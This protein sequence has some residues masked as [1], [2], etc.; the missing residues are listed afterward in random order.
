MTVMLD[1]GQN[2]QSINNSP[3]QTNAV[4]KQVK[5]WSA[6][7]CRAFKKL[8]ISDFHFLTGLHLY[9]WTVVKRGVNVSLQLCGAIHS[10]QST[11]WKAR[12]Y[13]T[14]S[15]VSS[16]KAVITDA[17]LWA[18]SLSLMCAH[19]HTHT[20]RYIMMFATTCSCCKMTELST[21]ACYILKMH[22]NVITSTL[23]SSK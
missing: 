5:K 6:T 16:N 13:L 1:G 17:D 4:V 8:R 10:P 18:L 7:W 11:L 19:T 22:L 14:N 2:L 20:Q 3:Y 9:V 21:L 15:V 23:R 12:R